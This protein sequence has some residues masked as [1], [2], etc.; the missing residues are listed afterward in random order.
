MPK[1]TTTKTAILHRMVMK[2][3]MCPFGLKSKDLLE[4][5]G[6]QVNDQ[7]LTSRDEVD[8]FKAEYGVTTTPQT[9]IDGT[10]IGGFDDLSKHFGKPTKAKDSLTY[11]PVIVLFSVALL[12]AIAVTWVTLGTAFAGR[13]IEWFISISM[14]LLGL[15]KL[16]DVERFATMFLNYDLLAQRWVRY[17]YVYP[18]VETGAGLLMMAGVLTWLSAPA[19]LVVAGIGA[20][21]VF[22]AVYIDKRELKCACVGGDSKVPLGFVS[23]IENLMMIGMALWMLSKL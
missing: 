6:Y 23:L 1:D 21:S 12:M 10:R 15:Q 17:G 3:H 19:A 22:K 13:T 5:Q 7:H 8:A 4:R 11:K 9:F 16:Q 2:D 14:V 18:F 20:V